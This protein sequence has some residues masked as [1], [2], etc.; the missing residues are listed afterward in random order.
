MWKNASNM[1]I[2]LVEDFFSSVKC[3]L[4]QPSFDRKCPDD[5]FRWNLG[6]FVYEPVGIYSK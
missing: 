3:S 5:A 6:R 2:S 1:L 4:I